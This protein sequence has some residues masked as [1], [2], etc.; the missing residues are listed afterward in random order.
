MNLEETLNERSKTHG[1]ISDQAACARA[2]RESFMRFCVWDDL[3]A[4][5]QQ[6][7][8]MIFT[9]LARIACGN[10]KFTDHWHDIAGYSS[11]AEANAK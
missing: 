1:H 6:C 10:P 9:K 7:L 5:H 2:L 4:I 8:L 11:L 3:S